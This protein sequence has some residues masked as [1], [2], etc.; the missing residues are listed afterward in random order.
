MVWPEE[1]AASALAAVA[2]WVVAPMTGMAYAGE[3]EALPFA[4]PPPKG[5][6]SASV[7]ANRGQVVSGEE[8]GVGSAEGPTSCRG[9]QKRGGTG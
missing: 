9:A 4:A 5:P 2:A 1:D 6:S 8:A 7:A 3:V